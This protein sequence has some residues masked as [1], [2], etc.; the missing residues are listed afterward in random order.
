LINSR[1]RFFICFFIAVSLLF[2]LTGCKK[3]RSSKKVETIKLPENIRAITVEQLMPKATKV[4]GKFKNE[5]PD[6][7]KDEYMYGTLAGQY[8]KVDTARKH[9]LEKAIEEWKT[10]LELAPSYAE[11]YYNLAIFM[12]DL[13]REEDALRLLE[14][15]IK[16]EPFHLKAR[17]ALG[18]MAQRKG[19]NKEAIRHFRAFQ[20]KDKGDPRV[21]AALGELYLL[22]GQHDASLREFEA[23]ARI[24]EK[25][26][27]LHY[28]LG[29][30]YH[31]R[32]LLDHAILQY[33]RV[34]ELSP[35]NV[36]AYVN[37]GDI[38]FHQ[39]EFASALASYNAALAISPTNTYAAR[40]A[41]MAEDKLL[42]NSPK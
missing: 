27:R 4:T 2:S 29:V 11:T 5:I 36:D 30:A 42:E 14:T 38:Y 6:S 3:R 26:P 28:Q 21:L 39:N 15:C 9:L 12:F 1:F 16:Y 41:K 22:E 7:V 20:N 34:V 32:N 23:A 13:R 10:T 35:D 8:G 17:Y 24:D 31:R 33:K 37:L 40:K 25:N 19:K 18:K